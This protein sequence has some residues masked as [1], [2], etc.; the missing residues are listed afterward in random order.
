MGAKA[1]HLLMA[2]ESNPGI[3]GPGATA[4]NLNQRRPYAQIGSLSLGSG[5]GWST[6][7]SAQFTL[8]KNSQWVLPAGKL[9]VFQIDRYFILRDH[10]NKHNRPESVQLECE[11]RP[12]GLRHR[13]TISDLRGVD[14]AG[15]PKDQLVRSR[16]AGGLAEQRHL[17]RSDRS[18]FDHQQRCRQCVG[19]QWIKLSRLDWNG[20]AFE[21]RPVEIRWGL[22]PLWF[23]TAAFKT[24]AVGTFGTGGRGQL[25]A[26]GAWNVSYSL[27]KNFAPREWMKIQFRGESFNV[28]ITPT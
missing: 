11:P 18:S 20:L 3:Y 7:N 8:Q 1:T 14:A 9:H 28:F 10:R 16:S 15:A 25:R 17:F 27:F 24:N 19:G 5:T 26:P 12:V 6:Y 4:G 13:P 23:N 22:L 21:W 2:A